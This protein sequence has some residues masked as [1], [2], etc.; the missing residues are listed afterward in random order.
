MLFFFLFCSCFPRKLQ[1]SNNQIYLQRTTKKQQTENIRPCC[2]WK[3]RKKNNG[4][5]IAFI[6]IYD[7][8]E[9]N[10]STTSL[11]TFHSSNTSIPCAR[12]HMEIAIYRH[13]INENI[14]IIIIA[15]QSEYAQT[16]L[17]KL[18]KKRKKQTHKVYFPSLSGRT[19]LL[20]SIFD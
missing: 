18:I 16:C 17:R 9:R 2:E 13:S 19:D 10:R 14:T 8:F 7:E 3:T 5:N 4:K 12:A 1:I 15:C 11:H 6:V 20:I